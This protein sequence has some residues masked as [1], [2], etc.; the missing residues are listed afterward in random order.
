M[1]VKKCYVVKN[2]TRI[3]LRNGFSVDTALRKGSKRGERR[4]RHD[5]AAISGTLPNKVV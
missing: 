4:M 2:A 1:Q 5:H 3:R